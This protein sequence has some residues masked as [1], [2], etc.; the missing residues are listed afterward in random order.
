MLLVS[1]SGYIWELV[2]CRQRASWKSGRFWR[3]ILV[4][5]FR[6]SATVVAGSS[7]AKKRKEGDSWKSSNSVFREAFLLASYCTEPPSNSRYTRTTFTATTSSAPGRLSLSQSPRDR[8]PA[9]PGATRALKMWGTCD[10]SVGNAWNKL[11]LKPYVPKPASPKTSTKKQQKR[12]IIAYLHC[13]LLTRIA[14]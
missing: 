4:N 10:R 14:S 6:H 1:N 12:F 5:N 11:D 9:W 3:T 8:A 2:F 7:S 13:K